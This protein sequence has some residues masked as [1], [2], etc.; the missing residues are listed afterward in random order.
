[1]KENEIDYK[2]LYEQSKSRMS[3]FLNKYCGKTFSE[4]GTM[5]K[6]IIEV[7]PELKESEDEKIIKKL[8][9]ILKS[10]QNSKYR[11]NPNS[12]EGMKISDIIACLEKLKD[13]KPNPYSGTGFEYNGHTW[14]MC[15]RDNGVDILLDKQ[16]F[17]HLDFEKQD[18]QKTTNKVEPKFKVGD[19]IVEKDP[20][21]YDYGTI[22]DIKDGQYIFTD[23]YYMDI[24]E[25]EGWQLVKTSTIIEQ[26][27]WNKEDIERISRI[28]DFI[29]KNRKGDTDEIY[30]QE[31]DVNWLKSLK[32]RVAWKPTEDQMK[33]L[34]AA[35]GKAYNTD[36]AEILNSLW[37][38]LKK[39]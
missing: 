8:I 34:I 10:Y 7:F 35:I 11:I 16:L 22:K 32:D 30:K 36:N 5:Y 21:E 33:A 12:W 20:D 4:D 15:A 38:D 31:L 25:Q 27:H 17:K 9:S 13:E 19:T 28:A 39:L 6:D 1:M 26:K 37:N 24:D 14:G 23:G 3:E 29:W 2:A 18:E